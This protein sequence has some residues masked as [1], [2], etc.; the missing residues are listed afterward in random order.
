MIPMWISDSAR[1]AAQQRQQQAAA[2]QEAKELVAR[3]AEAEKAR[4]AAEERER[5]EAAQRAKA[6]LAAA[7]LAQ[8]QDNQRRFAR[9]RQKVE[10][11][12]CRFYVWASRAGDPDVRMGAFSALPDADHQDSSTCREIAQFYGADRDWEHFVRSKLLSEYGELPPEGK[13]YGNAVYSLDWPA[14]Q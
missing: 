11:Y 10:A 12:D 14:A 13:R 5:A 1:Q 6:E 8:E 2:Q 7:A 3:Q 4:L 9:I